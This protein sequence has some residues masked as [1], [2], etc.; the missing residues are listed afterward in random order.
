MTAFSRKGANPF[1]ALEILRGAMVRKETVDG[2]DGRADESKKEGTPVGGCGHLRQGIR[3][4]LEGFQR[5]VTSRMCKGCTRKDKTSDEVKEELRRERI[6]AE[7]RGV[8]KYHESCRRRGLKGEGDDEGNEWSV[9][10]MLASEVIPSDLRDGEG[11]LMPAPKSKETIG[12]YVAAGRVA[13]RDSSA[14]IL[15]GCLAPGLPGISVTSIA[16]KISRL[17]GKSGTVR[18]EG[19][20]AYDPDKPAPRPMEGKIPWDDLA[21]TFFP[22]EMFAV[23]PSKER[24]VADYLRAPDV[25][26]TRSFKQAP[27]A[28][29]AE[30]YDR[31]P[32]TVKNWIVKLNQWAFD[33]E[34]R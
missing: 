27:S 34:K 25:S 31:K 8:V 23:V 6:E 33:N 18:V 16:A 24:T 1:N 19:R 9:W 28:Y 2:I 11:L 29:M 30:E 20:R 26:Y 32:A 12:K 21:E 3:C 15:A 4:D 5:L 22:P 17:R 7:E 13:A 10:D 14:I